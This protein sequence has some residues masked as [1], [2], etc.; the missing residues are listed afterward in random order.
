MMR[1]LVYL[2]LLPLLLGASGYGYSI[3]DPV[4]KLPVTYRIEE[5]DSRFHTSKE[6]V[7]R[8]AQKAELVWE[9]PIGKNL[10]TY[11]PEG[12]LPVT[13]VYDERQENALKE[14]ELQDDLLKKE[15]ANETV[16][17]EYA[18]LTKQYEKLE[19]T[20]KMQKDVYD[21]HLDRYN[22]KVETIN[23]QGGATPEEQEILQEEAEQLGSEA[24]LLDGV[25]DKL[26]TLGDKIN[27]LQVKGNKLVE[28][29][30]SVVD[31]YNETV[32]KEREFTQGDYSRDGIRIYQFTSEE[33]LTIVLA[34]E[35][36]HAVSIGHVEGDTSIMYDTMAKQ[37]IDFGL[38]DSDVQAFNSVCVERSVFE[39]SFYGLRKV[40]EFAFPGGS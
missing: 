14:A 27:S 13:F 16:A 10:F 37:A 11:S 33:E 7:I 3:L 24:R 9:T 6:E 12:K 2:I 31:S 5:I 8:I 28:D 39:Q 25:T 32:G 23:A 30:N 18:R 15:H 34:H 4:C 21:T 26:N 35:F 38:S 40:F 36:G 1:Y 20:Y 17:D 19:T 29:Y 22:T